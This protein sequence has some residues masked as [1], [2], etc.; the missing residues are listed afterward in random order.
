MPLPTHAVI[1]HSYGTPVTANALTLTRYPVQSFTMLGSA[2]LDGKVVGT[3]SDLNI[4][5]DRWGAPRVFTTQ[6]AG[7]Q[8][9]PLGAALSDRAQPN[10]GAVAAGQD[11][12]PGAYVAC[13]AAMLR[14]V[15]DTS[16]PT[17]RRLSVRP[18]RVLAHC[19]M[20]PAGSLGMASRWSQPILHGSSRRETNSEASP[21]GRKPGNRTRAVR[22]SRGLRRNVWPQ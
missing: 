7:D 8:L 9:A 4:E 17:R 18:R 19:R 15:V 21:Q 2:G 5:R 20:C 22:E 13:S 14:Q 3:L 12:I 1:A 16:T 6:A 10:P 11:H